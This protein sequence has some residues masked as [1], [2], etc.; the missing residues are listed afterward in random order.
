MTDR[1]EVKSSRLA[2][3]AKSY[4][5]SVSDRNAPGESPQ[6]SSPP[7]RRNRANNEAPSS[8]CCFKLVKDQ[9]L[10]RTTRPV[11]LDCAALAL[12]PFRTGCTLDLAFVLVPNGKTRK[13]S[14]LVLVH[15]SK[16]SVVRTVMQA[17]EAATVECFECFKCLHLHCGPKWT[18]PKN[19]R[20]V[21][22]PL[23]THS[24]TLADRF[25]AWLTS[26][27]VSDAGFL[28]LSASCA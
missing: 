16:Y 12:S 25:E 28:S 8:S 15:Q 14:Q 21:R 27:H 1:R 6:L 7:C 9:N 19:T 22:S 13:L 11:P 26:S 4:R 20:T 5:D 17:G 18:W 3:W 24:S 2:A 23:L 10:M